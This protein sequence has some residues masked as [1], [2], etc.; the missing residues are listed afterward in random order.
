V[1][2]HLRGKNTSTYQNRLSTL[3]PKPIILSKCS[4]QKNRIKINLSMYYIKL[5]LSKLPI[6]INLSNVKLLTMCTGTHRQTVMIFSLLKC[7][8][9]RSYGHAGTDC[10][11]KCVISNRK[12]GDPG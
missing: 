6:K 9:R 5:N 7:A 4:Y 12:L 3:N 8:P 11:D 1:G 10:Q 2:E